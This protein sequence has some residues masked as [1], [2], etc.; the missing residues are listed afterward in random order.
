MQNKSR[1]NAR[2][3]DKRHDIK[4]GTQYT[5]TNYCD[6]RN[7]NLF[8]LIHQHK[9]SLLIDFKINISVPQR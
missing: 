9:M 3:L 4:E 7:S 5:E 1:I 2:I 8:T 6:N